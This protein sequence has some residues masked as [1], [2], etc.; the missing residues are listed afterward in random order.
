[1]NY[2]DIAHPD[3]DVASG[4]DMPTETIFFIQRTTL[5]PNFYLGKT[6]NRY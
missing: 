3:G 2:G 4:V 6:C 1:M 5:K